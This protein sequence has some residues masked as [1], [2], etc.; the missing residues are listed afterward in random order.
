V[1]LKRDKIISGC[2]I[3]THQYF[4]DITSNYVHANL[5]SF[6]LYG[7]KSVGIK[8]KSMIGHK[9]K[10]YQ[11]DDKVQENALSKYRLLYNKENLIK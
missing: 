1:C 4:L 9:M 5:L 11:L 8:V 2:L 6:P 7:M 10:D 3:A